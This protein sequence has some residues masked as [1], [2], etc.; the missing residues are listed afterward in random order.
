MDSLYMIVECLK[1]VNRLSVFADVIDKICI[2][3]INYIQIF[4]AKKKK[5]M[6]SFDTHLDS[7]HPCLQTLCKG[8]SPSEEEYLMCLAAP[9]FS[10]CLTLSLSPLLQAR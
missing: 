10:N 4:A 2:G 1:K 3:N 6:H 7:H 8:V 9:S 5:N